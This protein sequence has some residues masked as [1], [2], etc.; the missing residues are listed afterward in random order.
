LSG[1]GLPGLP[2]PDRARPR[3][4]VTTHA[5][6]SGDAGSSRWKT[7]LSWISGLLIL[8]GVVV[9]ALHFTEL[10]KLAELAQKAEPAWLLLAAALQAAT[11]FA[12][13]GAW[14]I[15]LKRTRQPRRYL[16]MV[17]LGLAKLFTDQA[18][19]TGGVGGTLLVVS[20]LHRRGVP[21]GIGMAALLIGMISFYAAYLAAVAIGF[22][23]L[24]LHDALN[25]LLVAGAGVFVVIA[26]AIPLCVLLVRR[27]VRVWPFSWL[28]RAIPALTILVDAM[29][30]APAKAMR[31]PVSLGVT[32]LFQFSVF[33]LDAATLWTVLHAVGSPAGFAQAFASFMAAS[34]AATL[35]PVP[36]GLGTFEAVST[37]TLHLQGQPVAAALAAT[38]LL[39]GFTFW[40]PMLPGLF[41][42]HRELRAEAHPKPAP[43]KKRQAA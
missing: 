35:G 40:L 5:S 29:E 17:P 7:A 31:D 13:A 27:W 26:L 41:L 20:G 6:T 1:I 39:R 21:K 4:I 24:F 37:A 22:V 23:I 14:W 15:V 18:L 12:A 30:Q 16:D 33:V 2:R 34:V 10:K 38:L 25:G 43:G 11:Y 9:V 32:G 8:A 3:G 42:A 36:L 28:E 19:P